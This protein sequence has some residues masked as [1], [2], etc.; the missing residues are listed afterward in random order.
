LRTYKTAG[1][2]LIRQNGNLFEKTNYSEEPIYIFRYADN[3]TFIT[4]SL[5]RKR[6]YAFSPGNKD[7]IKEF[8]KVNKPRGI[9][10]ISYLR[11]L[12]EFLGTLVY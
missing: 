7:K 8:M 1:N 4:K 12:T 2:E 9:K 11:K 10:N 6:L 3:K 5:N